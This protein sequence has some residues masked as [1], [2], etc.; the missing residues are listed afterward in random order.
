M[1]LTE[2][3][4]SNSRLFEYIVFNV[5]VYVEDKTELMNKIF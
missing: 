2:N 4:M 1:F 5:F 3:V